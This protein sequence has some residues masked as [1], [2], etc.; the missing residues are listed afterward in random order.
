M[1]KYFLVC[2]AFLLLFCGACA[3]VA[4]LDDLEEAQRQAKKS[5]RQILALFTSQNGNMLSARLTQE[6]SGSPAFTKE[7]GQHFVLLSLDFTRPSGRPDNENADETLLQRYGVHQFPAALLLDS[8][9]RSFAVCDY[10]GEEG[11]VWLTKLTAL[12]AQRQDRDTLLRNAAQEMDIGRRLEAFVLAIN[13]FSDWGI[14]GNYPELKSE[15][16]RLDENNGFGLRA[17]YSVERAIGDI[18]ATYLATNGMAVGLGALRELLREYPQ[19]EAAQ[20]IYYTM[21]ILESRL[22]R[23]GEARR[24][25]RN[26]VSAAPMSTQVETIHAALRSFDFNPD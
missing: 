13:T 10:R 1:R 7:A 24:L 26:A 19:G 5:G 20:Q 22:G 15:V 12:I 23:I 3:R 25:L 8:N 6:T 14:I 9:G 21:A 2:A 17:K 11:L 4:W 16:I 18:S